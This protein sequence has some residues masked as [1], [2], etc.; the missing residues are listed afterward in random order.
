MLA[1]WFSSFDSQNIILS[2]RFQGNLGLFCAGLNLDKV[3]CASFIKGKEDRD[4]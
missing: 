1:T 3:I 4:I 2:C